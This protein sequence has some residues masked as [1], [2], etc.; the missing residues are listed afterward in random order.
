MTGDAIS[1]RDMDAGDLGA[2]AAL[3]RAAFP[4]EDLVPLVKALAGDPA[5]RGFVALAGAALAG[6]VMFAR[7]A[8]PGTPHR[9]VLLGPLAVDP[10]RVRAGIGGQLVRHGLEEMAREGADIALVLGDPAYY[11]RFGFKAEEEIDMPYPL[12]PDW[13]GAWQSLPLGPPGSAPRGTLA[14][15]PPWQAPALW[16]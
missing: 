6:H 11:G 1:L 8:L 7:C 16:S 2:V 15:P 5:A 10:E 14:V 4:D 12:P 13:A 9:P 3:H